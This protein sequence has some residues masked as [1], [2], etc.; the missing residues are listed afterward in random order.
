MDTTKVK[1]IIGQCDDVKELNSIIAH[2]KRRADDLYKRAAAQQAAEAWERVKL[3][4]HG[5][6]LYCCASGTFVGGPLQRGDSMTVHCIQPR[7]KRLWVKLTSGEMYGLGPRFIA[8]YDL[9]T[10]PPVAPLPGNER[11]MAEA[12]GKVIPEI[13]AQGGAR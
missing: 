10:E 8:R 9:R 3:L 7:K 6:T 2:A 13:F 12:V 5:T 4:T 1:R 11:R